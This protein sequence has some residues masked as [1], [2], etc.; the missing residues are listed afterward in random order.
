MSTLR[1]WTALYDR[2]LADWGAIEGMCITYL[3]IDVLQ[4]SIR[5]LAVADPMAAHTCLAGVLLAFNQHVEI[6]LLAL[7]SSRGWWRRTTAGGSKRAAEEINA[8]KM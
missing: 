1:D 6:E 3:L 5:M 4:R 2:A 7:R 8:P